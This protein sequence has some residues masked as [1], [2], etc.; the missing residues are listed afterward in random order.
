M[1]YGETLWNRNFQWSDTLTFAHNG[2]CGVFNFC[3]DERYQAKKDEAVQN[4]TSLSVLQMAGEPSA[5]HREYM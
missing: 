4:Y 3:N 2:L 1:R 5:V